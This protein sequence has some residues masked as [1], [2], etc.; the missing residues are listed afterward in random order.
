MLWMVRYHW[1][2]GVRFSLNCYKY[3]AHI[4]LR[5]L[6]IPQVTPQRQEGLTQ[7]Y[8]FSIVLY[9]ITLVP[10]AEEIQEEDL[11]LLTPCIQEWDRGRRRDE[12][13][14]IG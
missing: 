3:W 7:G 4:I 1:T 6:V 11:G 13:L 2:E 5:R 8:L 14:W 9:G 10:L 12:G